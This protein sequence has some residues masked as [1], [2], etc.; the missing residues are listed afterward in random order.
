MPESKSSAAIVRRECSSGYRLTILL[1]S[2][3]RPGTAATARRAHRLR[4]GESR[5]S[6]RIAHRS[7]QILVGIFWDKNIV[8]GLAETLH[9]IA[10]GCHPSC[11]RHDWRRLYAERQP[12]N[13][14]VKP[15]APPTRHRRASAFIRFMLCNRRHAGS[16]SSARCGFRKSGSIAILVNSGAH[17][18]IMETAK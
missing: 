5:K 2:V 9:R 8:V 6:L 3:S 17:V 12:G 11:D 10:H 16:A 4:T 1:R 15:T 13:R 7:F 14:S 18:G